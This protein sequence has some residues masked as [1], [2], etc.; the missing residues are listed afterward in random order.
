VL[1]LGSVVLASVLLGVPRALDGRTF[2]SPRA[3]CIEVAPGSK[4]LQGF[5]EDL[6]TAIADAGVSVTSRPGEATLVVEVH[7]LWR[8]AGAEGP[9]AEA[10]SLSI[11]GRGGTRPLVLHY[12]PSDRRA[13][14]RALLR[15]L[16]DGPRES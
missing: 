6:A 8:P 9:A 11:R 12:A 3:V 16:E 2:G 13:A 14:A 5:A 7:G 1:R 10:V 15:R 4:E